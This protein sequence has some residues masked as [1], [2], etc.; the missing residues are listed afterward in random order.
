MPKAPVALKEQGLLVTCG[1]SPPNL[2]ST[3]WGGLGYFWNRWVFVLPVRYG[4]LSQSII[5]NAGE[6]C[7]SVPY[8]D[9]RHAIMQVDHIS[10]HGHNKFE[11]LHLHPVRAKT[12]QSYVVGD[13][14]M[15]L[16]C[17]VIYTGNT[18]ADVVAPDLK[19][20][21]YAKKDFHAMYFGEIIDIYEDV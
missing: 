21:M 20:E 8:S 9:L 1:K 6:F 12:V 10:G 15:H 13:C 2:M 14:G 4:K 17:K 7:V 18:T 11:E 19:A 3:H 16:E 5:T